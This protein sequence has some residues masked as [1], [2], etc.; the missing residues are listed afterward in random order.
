MSLYYDAA[1]VLTTASREGSLK[2]R[3]YENKLGLKS[4]PAHLYALISETAKYDHFLKDVID[5]AGFLP[6]E[7]KVWARTAVDYLCHC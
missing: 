5:A 7:K 4:K 6:Q 2:S 1:T 3:I